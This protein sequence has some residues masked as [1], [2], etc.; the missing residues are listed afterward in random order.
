MKYLNAIDLTDYPLLSARRKTPFF[1]DLTDQEKAL[2]V[3]GA[4]MP[5]G[6]W[7]MLCT[8]RD[9]KMYCKHGL[10]PHRGWRVTAVKAYFGI[11]GSKS[12]LLSSF[13]AL[14]SEVDEIILLTR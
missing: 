11:K 9:L 1:Q 6:V 3:D 10:K 8:H 14:K 13:E 4:L 5:L 12:T 7:N 2:E